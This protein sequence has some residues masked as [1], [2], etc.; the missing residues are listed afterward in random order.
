MDPNQRRALQKCTVEL[1]NDMN[2]KAL[3][4]ALYAKKM[5]TPDEVERLQ[6]P[7]MTSRDQNMFILQK[8]PTKGSRA[9]DLFVDCLQET[10]EE[11]PIHEELAEQLV[12]ELTSLRQQGE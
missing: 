3:R 5:L 11:N 6:L 2:P 7:V 9:F 12:K 1:V 4:V 10:S 8:V